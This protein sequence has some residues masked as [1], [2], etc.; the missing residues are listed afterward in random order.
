MGQRPIADI[1]EMLDVMIDSDYQLQKINDMLS[2][3]TDAPISRFSPGN[4]AAGNYFIR[5]FLLANGG[6]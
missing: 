5:K 6:S 2:R 1:F 4:I 3:S